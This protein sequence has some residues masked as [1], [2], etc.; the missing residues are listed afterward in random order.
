[1]NVTQRDLAREAGVSL[2]TVARVLRNNPGVATATREKVLSAMRATGYRKNPLVDA[3]A[4]H[5]RESH[6]RT[7]LVLGHV[8]GY[9]ESAFEKNPGLRTLRKGIRERAEMIGAALNTFHL[10]EAEPLTGQRLQGILRGRGIPALICGPFPVSAP[11]PDLDWTPFSLVGIGESAAT[12]AMHR[13]VHSRYLTLRNALAGRFAEGYRRP[14]LAGFG[15]DGGDQ[16]RGWLP[17]FL[18]MTATL[19]KKDRV[20]W[21]PLET[22]DRPRFR[23]W[24]R[25]HRPDVILSPLREL[26]EAAD[27]ARPCAFFGIDLD[28]EGPSDGLPGVFHPHRAIGRGAVDLVVAHADVHETGLPRYPRKFAYWGKAAHPAPGIPK[29]IAPRRKADDRGPES[30]QL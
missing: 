12:R 13:V 6:R 19:P 20:P 11:P 10:G 5:F 9:S 8:T 21:L 15:P 23:E 30:R 1:M 28:E 14:G 26:A 7:D 16:A 17:A 2:A 29:N 22:A 25:R 27:T 3:W 18:Q 24:D 4:T